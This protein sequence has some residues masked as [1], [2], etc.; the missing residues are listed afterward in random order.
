MIRLT[1]LES[2]SNT[3]WVRDN[4]QVAL[5]Q[6]RDSCDKAVVITN[7]N[8]RAEL[9]RRHVARAQSIEMYAAKRRA[10]IGAFTEAALAEVRRVSNS[11]QGALLAHLQSVVREAE[12]ALQ[13]GDGTVRETGDVGADL[14][15]LVKAYAVSTV[16]QSVARN[17]LE[18]S[19]SRPGVDPSQASRSQKEMNDWRELLQQAIKLTRLTRLKLEWFDVLR[20]S[21]YLARQAMPF[22]KD[23]LGSYYTE[24]LS[25]AAVDA[26][27]SAR[28]HTAALQLIPLAQTLTSNAAVDST[29]LQVAGRMVRGIDKTTGVE[30]VVFARDVGLTAMSKILP[31]VISRARQIIDY[32]DSSEEVRSVLRTQD[33]VPPAPDSEERFTVSLANIRQF[34]EQQMPPFAQFKSARDAYANLT[35]ALDISADGGVANTPERAA[36]IAESLQA[37]RSVLNTYTK[38][39]TSYARERAIDVTK[40]QTKRL[41][42]AP[43]QRM[44]VSDAM[45][46]SELEREIAML[47]RVDRF[48]SDMLTFEYPWATDTYADVQRVASELQS[49]SRGKYGNVDTMARRLF[50]GGAR[51]DPK[52][53]HKRIVEF[54]DYVD[55][56][57]DN[58]RRVR[59]QVKKQLEAGVKPSDI[60]ALSDPVL[61]KHFRIVNISNPFILESATLPTSQL[62]ERIQMYKDQ[63]TMSGKKS[64]PLM[65]ALFNV[66]RQMDRQ[67]PDEVLPSD[68]VTLVEAASLG[69]EDEI[70]RTVYAENAEENWKEAYETVT[71]AA[72]DVRN[73]LSERQLQVEQQAARTDNVTND[74]S[75]TP[76]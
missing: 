39:A 29:A 47:E 48:L 56:L 12:A 34:M 8:A 5:S 13:N 65:T 11:G 75:R 57:I 76:S 7:V 63:V 60:Q 10:D 73:F 49:G 59:A 36:R 41:A 55:S 52:L 61:L 4:V 27:E 53:A 6:T 68:K 31:D 24:P 26:T 67:K 21:G 58:K 32:I 3:Q 43:V 45:Y 19:D 14:K 17:V 1:V 30:A 15:G 69:I 33:T 28:I 50:A 72:K 18:S 22:S 38:N 37:L 71:A 66:A 74:K 44:Q 23:G 54:K 62:L 35:E 42:S 40:S 9:Q 46:F 64:S 20:K 51:T 25:A 2:R 70:E 16:V